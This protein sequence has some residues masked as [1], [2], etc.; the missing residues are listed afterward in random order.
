MKTIIIIGLTPQGLS[1]LR[2][3]CRAGINVIAYYNSKK[4]V[5][6]FS[7]YGKKIYF[8]TINQLKDS[9][10]EILSDIDYKPLCYITS[11]E[12][13]AMVLQ[14]FPEL[15]Q[16]CDVIS[17]DYETVEKLAHKDC[18]Y[19]IAVEKGFKV[20]KYITL[21]KYKNGDFKFPI[22][23]KRNYE[24]PLFF[25][26]VK[27]NSQETFNRYFSRIKENERRHILVQ[28]FIDMH[29]IAHPQSQIIES[30]IPILTS[31]PGHCFP[32]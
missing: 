16:I 3:L 31:H 29:Y 19:E 22:F 2:I 32:E 27:I 4:N 14:S 6:R 15:Y 9:I 1:L 5:G 26:A 8:E 28:E 23:L 13:L 18:M 30:R 12:L 7:K 20:A 10:R 25:K 21:D 24:I 11:G 17:G